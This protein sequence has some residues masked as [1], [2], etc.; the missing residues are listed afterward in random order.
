MTNL[1]ILI[2][3]ILFSISSKAQHNDTQAATYNI[4]SGA[5]IGGIGAII[6]KKTNQKTH[7][8]VFKG[9][10]QGALGGYI[11][12]E[13]K[14]LIRNFADTGNY[15]YV[16]PSKLI[17]S[18]GNSIVLN[19]SSNRNFW[20]RIYLH[21]GF[22]HFEYDYMAKKKFKARILPTSLLGGIYSFTQG[23]LDLKRSLYTGNLI[24]TSYTNFE[25]RGRA[26]ANHILIN[27]TLLTERSNVIA[28]ELI[29]TYQYEDLM[30]INTYLD[31]SWIAQTN[32]NKFWEKYDALFYND[33]NGL[34]SHLKSATQVWTKIPH[35][36][37]YHEKEANYYS[38]NSKNQ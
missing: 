17:N 33:W 36:K 28:H 24:F 7:K 15:A 32:K 20:E 9:I 6:N 37:R 30:G 25:Y 38:I 5:I 23:N 26:T 8:V 22:G 21:I 34:V 10:G 14:R 18:A 19:A 13:S 4:I 27:K 16:W 11:V 1:K 35:D 12:F 31:N 29:H 3:A 2:L